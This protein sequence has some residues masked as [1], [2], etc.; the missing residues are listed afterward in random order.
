MK[1]VRLRAG[2][3]L[4]LLLCGIA[5]LCAQAVSAPASAPIVVIPIHGTVDDGMA[6]L[7]QRSVAE[8]NGEH[9]AAIVLDVDSP[10]GLV[11]SVFDIEDALRSAQVPVIAYV[12]ERAYSAAALITLSAQRIIMAP[13]ASIGAAEPIPNTP[14]EVSALTAEFESTAQRNHHNPTIAGA[15]VNRSIAIPG[16]K[17]A[18][19]ILT[20]NTVQALRYHVAI[21]VEPSL[22]AALAAVHLNANSRLHEHLTWA[23]RLAR[24]ATDPTVSGL[25]LSIGML[26]IMVELYTLHGIAGLIAI[27]AFG[28]FFGTHV[29]AGFSNWGVV[30]LAVLGFIGILWEL[31]VVPGHTFP[32]VLGG[33]AL[34]AAVVLA[35]GIPNIAVAFETLAAAIAL[36]I[37]VFLL[38]LRVLPENAWMHRLALT[39]AQGSDY[40]SSRDFGDLKGRT[41]IAASQLRPAGVASIDGRRID[42]LTEGEYVAQGTP[43]RVTRV[44][45]A[46]IFVEPGSGLGPT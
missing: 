28:L 22:D 13:G 20:L 39:Y 7:V 40:V 23:E 12:S 38:L 9:A 25:L 10:G 33:I 24:F 11:S 16:L 45:G 17:A 32:G 41:G 3:W 8:A 35:F 31:H 21:A 46:R 6:H 4:G 43:I 36:T 34:V 1:A 15:M 19:T 2:I 42:V 27:I 14:K 5:S 44:E 29:Y 37:V 18:G 30:A 26:G